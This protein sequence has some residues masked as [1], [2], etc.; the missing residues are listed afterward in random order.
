MSTAHGSRRA[1]LDRLGLDDPF[2]GRAA[3]PASVDLQGWNSDHPLLDFA[4]TRRRPELVIEVGVWKG[5]SAL[6]MA[7]LMDTHAIDGQI[8][9]I[10]T[11]LGTDRHLVDPTRRDELRRE[12]GMPGIY[13]VFLANVLDAGQQ[14]RIVPLPMESRAAARALA[15]LGVTADMLHIDGAHD[16][17]GCLAD[18]HGYWAI[19]RDDGV[20]V[21]DDYGHWPAVTRAVCSFAAE[22]DRAVYGT[23]G[24]AIVSKNPD[25]GYEMQASRE[26]SFAREAHKV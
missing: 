13:S 21:A 5:M 20:L 17:D 26:C 19:L 7:S 16:Y 14:G 4:M 23:M 9:A 25:L 18:L 6:H 10:D 8:L 15:D 11:W 1:L 12:A 24:K 3:D 2:D 22:V